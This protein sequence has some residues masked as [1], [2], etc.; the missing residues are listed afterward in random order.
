[1]ETTQTG[2]D[3]MMDELVRLTARLE[4]QPSES[5]KVHPDRLTAAGMSRDRQGDGVD[6]PSI[7]IYQCIGEKAEA[8]TLDEGVI[9]LRARAGNDLDRHHGLCLDLEAELQSGSVQK[10][11]LLSAQL[12]GR[13]GLRVPAIRSIVQQRRGYDAY[14]IQSDSAPECLSENPWL[15]GEHEIGGFLKLISKL[16]DPL[17]IDLG[18]LQALHP[19][20]SFLYGNDVIGTA[21]F[22]QMYNGFVTRTHVEL[23]AALA[24][25]HLRPE[26]WPPSMRRP[27]TAALVAACQK[28][29]VS[30]FMSG[31]GK[32]LKVLKINP[33]HRESPEQEWLD[34]AAYLRG[35]YMSEMSRSTKKHWLKV[36][37]FCRHQQIGVSEE[38]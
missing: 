9:G 18:D 7:R 15:D 4:R 32:G 16:S 27:E 3:D 2:R 12:S 13:T 36:R 34:M 22:W 11:G 33:V 23:M 30:F 38:K 31:P 14:V 25:D 5:M 19:R 29:L 20:N 21:K 10:W 24:L 26:Q 37:D 17:G 1:M 35:R 6:D 8:A 28:R